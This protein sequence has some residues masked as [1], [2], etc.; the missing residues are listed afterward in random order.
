MSGYQRP[1]A[2]PGG[3]RLH[4]NENTRGCSPY[5]LERLRRLDAT[6]TSLYPDYGAAVQTAARW[7]GVAE[8]EIVLTN[9]MD[10]GIFCATILALRGRSDGEGVVVEPAFDVYEECIKALAGRVRH[11]HFG[12]G[13]ALDA[14]AVLEH[15]NTRTRIVFLNDPHNPSGARIAPA[16]I[17]SIATQAPDAIVFVDEAYVEFG[18]G[19]FV[20]RAVSEFSNVLV[21]RTFAKAY[22]L[23][24]LRVGAVVGPSAAIAALRGIVPPYSLNSYATEA[25]RAALED[26]GY[27]DDYISQAAESRRIVQEFCSRAGL[28]AFPSEAN[29]VLLRIGPEAPRVVASLAGR[30]IFIRDRSD[31]PGCEGCVRLTAGFVDDTRRAIAALEEV[32]CDVP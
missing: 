25:L 26:R 6:A 24:G 19:S 10:E 1:E 8:N 5:V 9:G 14:A 12:A 21:G 32:L 18:T 22:G 3:L 13:F 4:L 31:Q 29:F 16:V 7:F 11:A 15:V 2:A 23:A 27:V 28:E 20:E 17:A 30:G